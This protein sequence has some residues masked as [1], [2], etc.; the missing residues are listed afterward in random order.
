[1]VNINGSILAL[2]VRLCTC[3][4]I[5]FCFSLSEIVNC[6]SAEVSDVMHLEL[7]CIVCLYIIFTGL[8]LGS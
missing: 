1:M 2:S 6:K 7:Y 8:L 5:F 3:T 4:V